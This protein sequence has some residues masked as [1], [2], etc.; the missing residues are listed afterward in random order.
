MA[1][2]RD[3]TMQI[4]SCSDPKDLNASEVIG[5]CYKWLWDLGYTGQDPLMIP[6][7]VVEEESRESN[8]LDKICGRVDWSYSL[9]WMAQHIY[10]L[11][12]FYATIEHLISKSSEFLKDGLTLRKSPLKEELEVQCLPINFHFQ[13]VVSRRQQ[14]MKSSSVN[15]VSDYTTCGAMAAHNL[16]HKGGGLSRLE[17]A[18]GQEKA[19]IE[20]LVIEYCKQAQNRK[21]FHPTAPVYSLFRKIGPRVEDFESNLLKVGMRR[22]IC[23]TQLISIAVNSFMVKLELVARGFIDAYFAE[24]WIEHSFPLIF[25]SLL[26]VSGKEKSM[27][28]DAAAVIDV[29][30]KYYFRVLVDDK[31]SASDPIRVSGRE[32]KLYV[33]VELAASLPKSYQEAMGLGA[34][35]VNSGAPGAVV[36]IM[37]A[38]FTL[39]IDIR[40][41][42]ATTW[43]SADDKNGNMEVQNAINK[44]GFQVL[45]EFCYKVKP[46]AKHLGDFHPLMTDFQEA[47]KTLSKMN[48]AILYELEKVS[49]ALGGGRVT[50]CKS[51]KD[52][53]GMAVTLHQS[54]ELSDIYGF[55]NSNE[56]IIRDANLMRVYGTRLMVAEKNIGRAVFAI[57]RLQI[58][59][60]PLLYRPP[61]SVLEDVFKGSDLS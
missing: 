54:R 56:R 32:I 4:G 34:E 61:L 2:A 59:F 45:N 16:G 15:E 14:S 29:L 35:G 7:S 43:E 27:L 41:A 42:M 22:F 51:G 36:R 12:K 57:N 47:M 18:L 24:R 26:S 17:E 33:P 48:V 31:L 3:A 55:E 13:F 53:T 9:D 11:K 5:N 52:R 6:P 10:G 40:Q 38:L 50:F 25:E 19:V 23:L 58:Q 1:M 20:N 39:G 30:Q 21:F 28:E 44:K 37:T 46:V 49:V 60:M 8:T